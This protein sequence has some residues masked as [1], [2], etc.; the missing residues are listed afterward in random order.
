MY[1]EQIELNH[2]D[3]VSCSGRLYTNPIGVEGLL[4]TRAETQGK[5]SRSL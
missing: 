5:I 4:K 1:P 2:N 3:S